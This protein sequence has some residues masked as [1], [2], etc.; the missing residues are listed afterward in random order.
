[1]RPS[2]QRMHVSRRDEE[3]LTGTDD[4]SGTASPLLVL[5]QRR[6]QNGLGYVFPPAVLFQAERRI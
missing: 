1:M 5:E 2:V 6:G 4:V 3:A